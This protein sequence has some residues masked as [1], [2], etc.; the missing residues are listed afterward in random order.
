MTD[1]ALLFIDV[2]RNMLVGDTA[3]PVAGTLTPVLRSLLDRA[4]ASGAAVV[5]VLNDGGPGD[6]DRP[7]TDGWQPVFEAEPGETVVRK[8]ENDTFAS[9][10]ELAERLRADGVET[11]VIAGLQSEY[12][13]KATTLSALAAGFDVRLVGDGHGTYPDG[14]PA[15]EVAA[16]TNEELSRSGVTV[17]PSAEALTG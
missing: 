15:E 11:V 17:V 14:R 13:V 5:H 8:T 1:T 10:P 12:C 7:G 3:S 9:N 4:R 16:E 6:P 2:Q